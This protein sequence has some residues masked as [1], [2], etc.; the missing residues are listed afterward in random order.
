MN[1]EKKYGKPVCRFKAS[2]TTEEYGFLAGNFQH[3]GDWSQAVYLYYDTNHN[4]A[5]AKL[6]SRKLRLRV[7]I[8]YGNYSVELKNQ[9]PG[10]KWEIS[11]PISAEEF[12]L[13]AQQVFPAG[14]VKDR[15]L[16]FNFSDPVIWVGAANTVRKKIHFHNGVLVLDQTEC[17]N[18]SKTFFQVEFRSDSEVLPSKIKFIEDKLK[19]LTRG[20][21]SKEEEIW[22]ED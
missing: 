18:K 9:D 19:V 8:K 5:E 14:E 16:E 13:M 17:C 3:Y 11:Q 2:L 22:S 6:F 1:V 7:R 20:Y 15:L 21:V 10:K 12:R 4:Q